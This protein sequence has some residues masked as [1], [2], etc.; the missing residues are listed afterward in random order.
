[1]AEFSSTLFAAQDPDRTNPV[2]LPA[3]NQAGGQIHEMVV[4]VTFTGTEAVNDTINLAILPAG[5]IPVPGASFM[6]C[7][8]IGA[9]PT[10]TPTPTPS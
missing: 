7:E 5:A 3:P 4:P 8:T 1:M 9:T 6:V 10:P 2:R